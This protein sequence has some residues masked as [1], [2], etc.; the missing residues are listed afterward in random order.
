MKK[1]NNISLIVIIIIITLLGC[2]E[3]KQIVITKDYIIN[4]NWND[5]VNLLEINKLNV[6]ENFIINLDS[7]TQ[8][9]L[10]GNFSEDSLW[11][12]SANVII[13]STESYKTK[14]IYFNEFN[15]FYWIPRRSDENN[16][17]KIG[18]LQNNQWYKFS[19]LLP[20]PYH[21]Y[22]YIDST[23]KIHRYGVDMSNW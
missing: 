20:Y 18:S 16:I 9:D 1:V 14:K 8:V 13:K 10:L 15:G 2:F 5:K 7:L 21:I 19:Y 17:E 11:G 23:D 6:N 4:P 12:Y 3:K 22:V